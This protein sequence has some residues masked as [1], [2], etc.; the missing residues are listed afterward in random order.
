MKKYSRCPDGYK[1]LEEHPL[2]IKLFKVAPFTKTTGG[3]YSLKIPAQFW[4][5]FVSDPNW[6][7]ALFA[8]YGKRIY[9][10]E[11]PKKDFIF[12]G[13]VLN[14]DSGSERRIGIVPDDIPFAI[15]KFPNCPQGFGKVSENDLE[16]KLDYYYLDGSDG[17]YI[18][19]PAMLWDRFTSNKFW[20]NKMLNK[21]TR[22]KEIDWKTPEEIIKDYSEDEFHKTGIIPEGEM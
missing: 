9:T 21:Y 13:R 6:Q 11:Y 10:G 3:G 14:V 22:L 18:T 15:T 5:R 7:D 12:N 17:G 20:R 19:V 4:P 8:R 1:I 16:I 2:Y